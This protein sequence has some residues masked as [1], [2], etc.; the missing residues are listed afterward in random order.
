[1]TG[2]G[3]GRP[4]LEAGWIKKKQGEEKSD[5]T[6]L[7]RRVDLARPDQKHGCNPLIFV[8]LTKTTSF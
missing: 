2:S 8:F 4:E 5:V 3:S 6:R 1:L 7:T